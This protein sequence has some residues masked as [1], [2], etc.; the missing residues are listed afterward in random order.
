MYL[1]ENAHQRGGIV[2]SAP[3]EAHGLRDEAQALTIEEGLHYRARRLASEGLR[4]AVIE[5]SQVERLRLR[6]VPE[7]YTYSVGAGA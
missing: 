7:R 1:R 6:E 2:K 3:V 5:G 4:Q